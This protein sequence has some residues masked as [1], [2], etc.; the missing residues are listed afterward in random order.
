MSNSKN[1]HAQV[2]IMLSSSDNRKD[3]SFGRGAAILLRGVQMNG[4]LNKTAKDLHMAYSK[5]WGMIK[6]VEESLG[7]K[8]INRYG[9]RGSELTEEGRKFLDLYEEYEGRVEAY[10]AEAFED[11]FRDF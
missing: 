9:A 8:L 4:S 7:F 11:V 3:P 2:K 10:A 1:L 6:K 5:A